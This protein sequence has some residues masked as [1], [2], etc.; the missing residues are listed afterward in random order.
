MYTKEQLKENLKEMGLLPNDSIMVHSSM[1]SIGPVEGGGETVIN[2]LLEY[3][4]R[5]LVMMPAH[6]WAQMGPEHSLY[7]PATEPACVGILPNLLLKRLGAVRSLHPTHSI[8]AY[9]MGAEAYVQGEENCTTPCTPGGCWDRLRKID[10]KIL[11]VGVTHIRNTFIHSIE[12]VYQVPER[13]TDKPVD[14]QIKMSDA[15]VKQ[16]SVYRHYNPHT[17]HISES[18]DKL[19]E[20]FYA[21]EAAKKGKFGD[22]ASILC[23]AGRLF[24]VT[25]RILSHELNCLMDRETIP[26]EWWK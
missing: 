13:F 5:G 22:A 16:V 25:G 7:D 14:F 17:E 15:S 1:K 9:G 26:C 11:L 6:T 4:D 12:E 23:D 19:S 21:T 8:V 10:A 3:F 2:A 20:A 24:E 18:Y